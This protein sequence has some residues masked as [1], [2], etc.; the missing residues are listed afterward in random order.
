MVIGDDEC[1]MYDG[2]WLEHKSKEKIGIIVPQLR[3]NIQFGTSI[4]ILKFIVLD[5]YKICTNC[6]EV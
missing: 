3:L 5:F 4:L 6:P 2:V 1:M